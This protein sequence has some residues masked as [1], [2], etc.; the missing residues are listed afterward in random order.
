[1]GR[2]F[3]RPGMPANRAFAGRNMQRFNGPQRAFAAAGMPNA[4][5]IQAT[6]NATAVRQAFN[7]RPIDRAFRNAGA[8]HNPRTRALVTAGLATAAWGKGWNRNGFWW[9]HNNGGFGWVGPVFWPFAFYDL[10]NYALWGYGYD[11]TFWDYGYPDIAAGIFGLYGYDGL[12]GYAGYLPRYAGRTGD[13]RNA[14]A[15]AASTKSEPNFAQLCG[16]ENQA[17][18][19]LPI[20]TFQK[21]VQPDDAQRAALDELASASNKAAKDLEASCPTDIALT[22]PRRLAVMQ[23]RIEAMIA[24]VQTVQTPLEKFYSLLNDEQKARINALASTRPANAQ[25]SPRAEANATNPAGTAEP[26]CIVQPTTMEWPGAMIEQSVKPTEAQRASLDALKDAA[27]KAADMLK[28]TCQPATALT[29]PAR[30][31]AIGQR[32]DTMLQAVK[33][34]SVALNDFYGSLSDEQKAHFDA[35][36][37]QLI[38]APGPVAGAPRQQVRRSGG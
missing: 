6:R 32:L 19:G 9:R 5:G 26:G 21:A 28:N 36:G 29:P 24:A 33:S 17:I 16:E 20:D 10:Y 4:R 37:P 25:R 23:Q 3:A 35:I 12:M 15:Y 2:S 30:L 7:S 31:A 18:A 14:Y 27:T 22:A 38:A 13:A 8:L 34:V 1:M 11:N